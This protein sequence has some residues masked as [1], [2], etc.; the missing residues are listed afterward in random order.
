MTGL[1]IIYYGE[2]EKC[3]GAAKLPSSLLLD[4]ITV[5]DYGFMGIDLLLTCQWPSGVERY[6]HAQPSASIKNLLETSSESIS[7]LAYLT[8]PRYHFSSGSGIY[9]ERSPYR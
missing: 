6:L 1:R 7:R 9:F 2:Y 4:A 3:L 8:R 5:E